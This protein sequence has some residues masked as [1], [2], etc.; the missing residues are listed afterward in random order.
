MSAQTFRRGQYGEIASALPTN[1]AK[2][3]AEYV[4]LREDSGIETTDERRGYW[5]AV[6]YDVY[7]YNQAAGVAV[8]QRRVAEKTKYGIEIEK[9]Y[10]LV[11]SS[12]CAPVFVAD[13]E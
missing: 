5:T 11:W 2:L 1:I 4:A 6:N 13:A 3:F 7:G 8:I 10:R 12:R 9:R